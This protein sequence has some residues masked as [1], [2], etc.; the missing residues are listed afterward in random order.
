MCKSCVTY[1]LTYLLPLPTPPLLIHPSNLL[2][3]QGSDVS[4]HWWSRMRF[5]PL[6]ILVNFELKGKHLVQYKCTHVRPA[7]HNGS[8]KR[9]SSQ[10]S[11]TWMVYSILIQLRNLENYFLVLM[12]HMRYHCISILNCLLLYCWTRHAQISFD[13]R[14]SVDECRSSSYLDRNT[15]T[16]I[17]A[18]KMPFIKLD[19][20]RS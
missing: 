13:E 19:G 11:S 8:P 15:V 7:N 1:L 10:R 3:G 20:G 17:K 5:W 16:V 12:N 9:S 4:S 18:L 6:T 2:G 14:H